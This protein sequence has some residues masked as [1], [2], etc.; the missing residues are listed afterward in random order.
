MLLVELNRHTFEHVR[1]HGIFIDEPEFLVV[2]YHLDRPVLYF[3]G[4]LA[5]AEEL[6]VAVLSHAAE[7]LK[8]SVFDPE[9]HACKGRVVS[10]YGEV[11]FR[12]DENKFNYVISHE[13]RSR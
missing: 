7:Y 5:V 3:G 1:F 12:Y 9:L 10:P 2:I 8:C 13:T 4:Y 6:A 11:W